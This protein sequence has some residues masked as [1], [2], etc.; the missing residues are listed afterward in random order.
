MLL[1]DVY[2]NR[3]VAGSETLFSDFGAVLINQLFVIVPRRRRPS[4]R[5]RRGSLIVIA[6]QLYY[7]VY[8]PSDSGSKRSILQTIKIARGSEI[9][10]MVF[11][12]IKNEQIA[13]DVFVLEKLDVESGASLK[14]CTN[15]CM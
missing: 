12:F 11:Y 3:T 13:V 9:P 6:L 1:C 14:G 15:L 10:Q 7:S 2:G 5:K 4:S 8:I